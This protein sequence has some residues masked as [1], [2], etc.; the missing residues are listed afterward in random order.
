MSRILLKIFAVPNKQASWSKFKN[1]GVPILVTAPSAPIT[2]GI[3]DTLS[4]LRIFFFVFPLFLSPSSGRPSL[5]LF[6]QFGYQND[7]QKGKLAN[8]VISIRLS[9]VISY[10]K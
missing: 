9:V 1:P 10:Y 7:I 6:P 8:T 3:T 4:Q 2:T 5:V